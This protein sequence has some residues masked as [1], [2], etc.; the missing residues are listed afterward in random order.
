MASLRIVATVLD[1]NDNLLV[2][3]EIENDISIVGGVPILDDINIEDVC[4][5]L[6]DELRI[7]KFHDEV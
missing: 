7:D 5:S 4:E 6:I 3:A 2:E 1:D